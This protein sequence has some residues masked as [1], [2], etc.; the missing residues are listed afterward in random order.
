MKSRWVLK[1]FS[2]ILILCMLFPLTACDFRKKDKEE[3]SSKVSEFSDSAFATDFS[4]MEELISDECKEKDVEELSN[5]CSYAQEDS[6][7]FER[8]E[9]IEALFS[10][11]SYEIDEESFEFF[12]RNK[13][14]TLSVIFYSPDL[15]ELSEDET[16]DRTTLMPAFETVDTKETTITFKLSKVDKSWLITDIS[17]VNKFI[18]KQMEGILDIHFHPDLDTAIV[19]AFWEHSTNGR[20]ITTEFLKY[21]I[22][23]ICDVEDDTISGITYEISRDSEVF[24]SGRFIVDR[25]HSYCA[26]LLAVNT[27]YDDGT[28]CFLVG[29]YSIVFY[30]PDGNIFLSD[31]CTVL[32]DN[33]DPD[34]GNDGNDTDPADEDSEFDGMSSG[35]VRYFETS[36]SFYLN[37]SAA[38]FCDRSA[39][40]Q[41]YSYESGVTALQFAFESL[42]DFGE[43]VSYRWYYSSTGRFEDSTEVG[44]GICSIQRYF[45]HNV[46]YITYSEDIPDGYYWCVIYSRDGSVCYQA[47]FVEVG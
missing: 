14:C 37:T 40:S 12:E 26:E 4:G 23:F 22:D 24:Y 3:I 8:S 27:P 28:G 32:Y 2:F 9:I 5:L 25:H 1:F 29:E 33:Y 11:C 41:V 15:S 47:G 16:K 36:S 38:I 6:V 21:D 18:R 10:N 30:G 39:L 46:Y 13:K 35:E 34:S 19:S 45:G 31:I 43:D 42:T 44:S 20:Y 7:Y 17:D